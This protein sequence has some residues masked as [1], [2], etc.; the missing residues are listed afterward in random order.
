M[1]EKNKIRISELEA[2]IAN[3]QKEI[4]QN[5]AKAR[6][7]VVQGQ[8]S[9]TRLGEYYGSLFSAS[10]GEFGK[11]LSQRPVPSV[12]GWDSRHWQSWKPDSLNDSLIRVGDLCEQR[13]DLDFRVPGYIPFIGQNKTIIIRSDG[14]FEKG[15]ALMQSLLVRTAALL[16]QQAHYTLL[17]PARMGVAFPMRRFLTQVQKHQGDVRR[18]LDEVILHIQEIIEKYIDASTLSFELV[19]PEIRVNES[20]KFVFA[21]DF[22]NHYDRRAIEALQTIANTGPVAG[23][24]VF[25]HHSRNH[26][27]P[28]DISMAGFKNAFYIDV[29]GNGSLTNLKLGLLVDSSPSPEVQSRIFDEITNMPRPVT[30]IPWSEVAAL[31]E[32]QWWAENSTRIIE[33]PIGVRGVKDRLRLWFGVNNDGR[34]CVHGMVGAMA[35]SGKSNL[36]HV[37]ITS[38]AIRYSPEELRLYLIDGK[39]GAEFQFYDRLPHAEVVSLN[40]PSELSRSVLSEL[41]AEKER[42]NEIFVRNHVQ[43]LTGYRESG[44]PEGRLP[45]ILLLVDEYQDLFE[46]DKD[47]T[48][49]S[50]LKQLSMQGRSAGV[51]MLLGSQRFGVSQMLYQ[52]DIFANVHL[53]L[54][55]QMRADHIQALTQFGRRGKHLIETCNLPGKIVI[56]DAGGTDGANIAGQV[57]HLP[58]DPNLKQV[59]RQL[60]EKAQT[61]PEKSLPRRIVFNGKEQPKLTDNQY[62]SLLLRPTTWLTT[63]GL[64]DLASQA[65]EYGGFGISDWFPEE[66]PRIGWLGQQFNMRGQAM[67]VFRRRGAENAIVI[68]GANAA[69]YGMLAALLI[70]IAANLD[71]TKTEFAIFDRSIAG[72]RWNGA[73]QTVAESL[74][75]AGFLARLCKDSSKADVFLNDLIAE[76]ARRKS[77]PEEKLHAEPSLFVAMTELDTVEVLRRPP[78]AYGYFAAS[79]S[80]E[81]LRRLCVEGAPLGIHLILS[82]SGVRPMVNVIDE[83]RALVN[84]RHRVALQM[85]EDDSFTLTRG[86]KASQLQLDG[87]TP[88]CALGVDIENDSS[89]R[90]KPYSVAGSEV[91]QSDS[92]LHQIVSI[93]TELAKRRTEN[94][95]GNG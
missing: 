12:A 65:V 51:H 94:A 16:P 22:P 62:L 81:I 45:R 24:Y 21:A 28:R 27:L 90:F 8:E 54:A 55:L 66:Q 18:D 88:I 69:R 80:G 35:G 1:F 93:G 20:F 53:L 48:A 38:L 57:A 14:K 11:Q 44:E 83:R 50:Y 9:S 79:A 58:V 30:K 70:T 34:P 32:D 92:L 13:S 19:P 77:L 56:N 40:T 78:D 89:V 59:V 63:N 61:L 31:P 47:G 86:R 4:K 36:Y 60:V 87:P 91:A 68:G 95:T 46:G 76:L 52:Q 75:A 17:D 3:L 84:F 64:A 2:C 10:G 71:P 15:E 43:D 73:L 72:S 49:S 7:L 33:A 85:S 26:E 25:I 42:R 41:V 82:F 6:A 29:D 5:E 67:V 39:E 37:L 74:T 23:T